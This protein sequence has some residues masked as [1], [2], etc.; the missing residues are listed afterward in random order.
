MT[1]LRFDVLVLVLAICLVMTMAI[2]TSAFLFK[3]WVYRSPWHRLTNIAVSAA[4]IT[5]VSIGVADEAVPLRFAAGAAF[6]LLYEVANAFLIR[7][8]SF[9]NDRFLI[10]RGPLPI[11]LAAGLPWGILPVVATIAASRLR[12]G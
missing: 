8:W 7:V 4:L 5:L 2:E 10:F 9:P 6:G 3:F 11:S 1:E 12:G